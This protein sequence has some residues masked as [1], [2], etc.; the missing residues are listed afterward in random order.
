VEG[1]A[2][3][4]QYLMASAHQM[5]YRRRFGTDSPNVIGE[6]SPQVGVA[7]D[8]IGGTSRSRIFILID[9][10]DGARRINSIQGGFDSHFC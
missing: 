9:A 8:G 7:F 1:Y 4:D 2:P 3:L 5:R 6:R 10:V